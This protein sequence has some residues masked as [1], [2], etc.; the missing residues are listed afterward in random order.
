[1]NKDAPATPAGQPGVSIFREIV[2]SKTWKRVLF[3]G[4][5]A[6]VAIGVL[7]LVT[8]LNGWELKYWF[9]VLDIPLA[10]L[11]E[12]AEDRLHFIADLKPE[13]FKLILVLAYT[14]YWTFI[15]LLLTPIY[16]FVRVGGVQRM[17]RDRTCRRAFILGAG[18]GMFIGGAN[19]MAILNEVDVLQRCFDFLDH[20]GVALAKNVAYRFGR[21]QLLPDSPSE[22]LI[23]ELVAA[24]AY[25]V[26]IGLLLAVVFSVMRVLKMR[27]GATE[28]RVS[29]EALAAK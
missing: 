12:A 18:A 13:V 21:M 8:E 4:P 10:S 20:P 19:F 28:P 2:R 11:I 6:G 3:F 26:S 16:R 15:I 24:V 27:N 9:G 1:M 7:N 25:W 17:L 5:L 22:V 29:A 23:Y 14:A